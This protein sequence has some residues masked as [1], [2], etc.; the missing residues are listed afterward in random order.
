MTDGTMFEDILLGKQLT[1]HFTDFTDQTLI[2]RKPVANWPCLFG[3]KAA[4]IINERA[5]GGGPLKV[6]VVHGG[7]GRSTLEL[8][9]HCNN[10]IIDHSDANADNF[11]ILKTLLSESHLKWNQQLEGQIVEAKEYK[12]TEAETQDK[13]LAAKNNS[14]SYWKADYKNLDPLMTGYDVIVADFRYKDCASHLDHALK[15]LKP[16]GI[17]VQGTIDDPNDASPG[18]NHSLQVLAKKCTQI[19]QNPDIPKSFPHI[20]RQTRNKHQYAISYFSAWTKDL[21]ESQDSNDG[22]SKN[23]DFKETVQ[24]TADYYEDQS[25][26]ESYDRFHFGEGLLSVKNFPLRMAE[27]CIEACKKYGNKMETGANFNN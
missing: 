24:T 7:V 4:E 13:L 17:L 21:D 1:E 12:L 14:V 2:D 23:E 9:R 5:S 10:L 15:R 19:P 26:L 25:I 18:P 20:Y 8:L 27:V 6:L 11:E 3:T 16:G 22:S